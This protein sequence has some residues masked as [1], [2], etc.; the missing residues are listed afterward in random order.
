MAEDQTTTVYYDPAWI[1]SAGGYLHPNNGK[2]SL[3]GHSL[4]QFSSSSVLWYFAQSPF[5]DP[6]SQ[7]GELIAQYG[8]TPQE[9]KLL[10]SKQGW[11]HQL[12]LRRGVSY[13]VLYDPIESN[14]RIDGPNGKEQAN[15]W[16]IRKQQTDEPG[17]KDTKVLGYYFIMN[18]AIYE[19]P[20]VASI[21][22][23]RM[24]RIWNFAHDI[25]RKLTV[26]PAQHYHSTD[27]HFHHRIWL[28]PLLCSTR[29]CIQKTKAEDGFRTG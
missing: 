12:S 25:T 3:T 29:P 18:D 10:G 5:F 27:Q 8:G 14:T 2:P 7:N 24:V 1:A 11:H 22:S 9:G 17:Q 23:T 21:L 15:T 26:L 19:A 6:T 13:I 16:V 20:S 4:V 28:A